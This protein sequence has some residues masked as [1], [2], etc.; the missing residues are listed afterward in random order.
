M[1]AKNNRVMQPKQVY[2]S[3]RRKKVLFSNDFREVIVC[4]DSTIIEQ[5]ILILIL[6]AVKFEQNNF[7]SKRKQIKKDEAKQLSFDDYFDGWANQGYTE[8][9]ISFSELKEFKKIKNS[10]IQ[11]ALVNMSNINWFRLRD[12]SIN[13]YKAVPFIIDPRW[14][15]RNIFFKIDV[16]VMKHILN[17]SQYFE[18]RKE[19]PFVASTPNTLKFLLWILKFSKSQII[20]KSFKQVLNEMCIPQERYSYR[21]WFERDFLN[22]VKADLDSKNDISFNYSYSN[23][24]YTVVLYYTKKGVGQDEKFISLNDL[25]IDRTLKYQKRRRMLNDLNVRTLRKLYEVKGYDELTLKIRR[26][27]DPSLLGDEYIKTLFKFL[28]K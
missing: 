4:Q 7:I 10:T 2:T 13:G 22:P 21:S 12:E 14:N 17:V 28:E 19:L 6:T 24:E 18:I 26:K 27:I 5:R 1:G 20:K 8:F 9:N 3:N 23:G 11:T 25:Q 16:A 15:S